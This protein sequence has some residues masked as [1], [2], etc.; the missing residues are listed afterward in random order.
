MKG[1]VSWK[2][3]TQKQRVKTETYKSFGPTTLLKKKRFSPARPNKG[4]HCGEESRKKDK[5]RTKRIK[6]KKSHSP[7]RRITSK[8]WG[9]NS[10][11]PAKD[12]NWECRK[13]N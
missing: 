6:Q 9:G 8:D 7:E 12:L 4:S 3:V 5:R 1:V 13:C 10:K 2:N 11:T